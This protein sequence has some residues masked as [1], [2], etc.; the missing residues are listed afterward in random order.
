MK[1]KWLQHLKTQEEREEFKK[2]LHN[3]RNVLDKLAEIVYNNTIEVKKPDY[4]CPSWAHKQAHINGYNEAIKHF[5]EI[6]DLKDK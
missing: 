3:S 1:T 4:D 6:L 5:S 2:L